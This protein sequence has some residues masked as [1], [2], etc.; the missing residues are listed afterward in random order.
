MTGRP[1]VGECHIIAP[2]V[3]RLTAPNPSAMTGPGTNTYLVGEAAVV[4][5]DPGVEDEAH[6]QAVVANAPGP[7]RQILITHKHPDHTGGARTLSEMTG[8]PVRAEG[9]PLNGIYD[10]EFT[11][12]DAIAHGES[13]DLGSG[14]I[15][16]AI[17]TPGHT[18]DH[19]CFLLRGSGLLLAGDAIM[20][21]V[22]VV[23][24]PPD[25]DMRA[26]FDTLQTLRALPIR[27]VAPAHGR[28]LNDPAA[29]IEH[30]VV[31]RQQREAQVVSLLTE[32]AAS[33]VELAARIYPDVPVELRGMAQAQLTAHLIKLETDGDVRRSAGEVWL[34]AE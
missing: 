3:R 22:T 1:V 2:G 5:I 14:Q 23:I 19:L 30:I 32:G 25:G 26:Y 4:V 29:E 20:A 9:T 15:M 24:I 31:H 18:P 8:A 11:A 33:A 6:L 10:P 17:H 34:P 7:I 21:D 16:E 28:V 27:A 13:I 12:D